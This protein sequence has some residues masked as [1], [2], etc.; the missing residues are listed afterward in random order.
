MHLS[1]SPAPS[2]RA[3]HGRDVHAGQGPWGPGRGEGG[4]LHCICVQ[5]INAVKL[6]LVSSALLAWTGAGRGV[7]DAPG[8]CTSGILG[9]LVH[10]RL[11]P[12]LPTTASNRIGRAWS[13]GQTLPG[14]GQD[15]WSRG[16]CAGCVRGG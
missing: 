7:V 12:F 8:G 16:Q 13:A 14:A 15:Y 11:Q 1:T 3:A 10:P 4:F 6:H 2:S 5:L 9:A